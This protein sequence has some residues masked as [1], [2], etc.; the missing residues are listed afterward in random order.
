MRVAE[1][2]YEW[3]EEALSFV[4]LPQCKLYFKIP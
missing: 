2:S 1:N 3:T 4:F